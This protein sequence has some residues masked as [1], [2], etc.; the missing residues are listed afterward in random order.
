[1]DLMAELRFFVIAAWVLGSFAW[2]HE[3]NLVR[4]HS[5]DHFSF[6]SSIGSN[7]VSSN[8]LNCQGYV[9]YDFNLT[10]KDIKGT[11]KLQVAINGQVPGINYTI[12]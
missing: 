11:G 1:M 2:Y 7:F 6:D 9:F 4:T 5:K 3:N 8:D 10:R 12:F